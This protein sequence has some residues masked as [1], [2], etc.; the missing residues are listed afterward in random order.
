[1]SSLEA[2]AARL[3]TRAHAGQV[4]QAGQPYIGHPERVAARLTTEEAKVVAW[5]HDVIEDGGLGIG[6]LVAAGI[7]SHVA[8][9]VVSD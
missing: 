3:A 8:T 9:A 4:D 6:D 1:M 5:L 7:P 2:K